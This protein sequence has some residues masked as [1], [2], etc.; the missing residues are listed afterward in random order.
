M[1]E[2]SNQAGANT[3]HPRRGRRHIPQLRAHAIVRSGEELNHEWPAVTH[4]L[5]YHL[6]TRADRPHRCADI[7]PV[8]DGTAVDPH[9]LVSGTEACS[10][11]GTARC[12]DRAPA[13]ALHGR[14]D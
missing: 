14:W 13:A 7:G 3:P 11:R 1:R 5:D 2:P 12:G 6:R 4:D 10:L 9:Q 8:D